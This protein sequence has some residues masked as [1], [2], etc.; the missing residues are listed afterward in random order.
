MSIEY[1][2]TYLNDHLAGSVVAHPGALPGA[3]SDFWRQLDQVDNDLERQRI[4]AKLTVGTT[5]GRSFIPRRDRLNPPCPPAP[6]PDR[7]VGL[8]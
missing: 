1:L 5:S 3:N 6:D 4:S 7:S 2:A 8:T